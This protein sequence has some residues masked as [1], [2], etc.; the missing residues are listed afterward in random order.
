MFRNFFLH[1]DVKRNAETDK[2]HATYEHGERQLFD[3]SNGLLTTLNRILISELENI[4]ELTSFE[5]GL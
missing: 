3:Q 1:I 2:Y 4:K 5:E